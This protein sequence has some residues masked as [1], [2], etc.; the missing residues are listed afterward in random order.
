[1]PRTGRPRQPALLAGL[2]I[3][4]AVLAGCSAAPDRAADTADASPS[5][6]SAPVSAPA[7]PP[8]SPPALTPASPSAV[9]S[10]GST[11]GPQSAKSR[12]DVSTVILKWRGEPRGVAA[13]DAEAIHSK[14]VGL[15]GDAETRYG[16]GA[17]SKCWPARAT[18]LTSLCA[19]SAAKAAETART[20]LA[21]IAHE[22]P[23]T[24]TTLRGH[25]AKVVEAADA[26]AARSCADAP[27][28]P[29]TARPAGRRGTPSPR[30]TTGCA[31]ASTPP[32]R[33][34]DRPDR[35]RP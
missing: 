23:R 4:G 7:A 16:S 27:A 18:S 35:P 15:L 26:Y 24:F 28:P 32:S 31:T 2:A 34:A 17:G 10:G 21:W 30:P 8:A 29:P 12:P 6:A 33:P 5:G 19:G 3:A 11:S 14:A 25:A 20:S 22:D 1:M 9:P 13:P